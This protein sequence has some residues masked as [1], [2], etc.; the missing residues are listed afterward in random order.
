MRRG[1]HPEE[2][3]DR[4]EDQ[5]ALART[6][7]QTS[8]QLLAFTKERVRRNPIKIGFWIIGLLLCLLFNGEPV[9]DAQL[10]NYTAAID[11]IPHMELDQATD[12]LH[13]SDMLYRQS[14]GWFWTCNTEQCQANKNT[15]EHDLKEVNALAQVAREHQREANAAVGLFSEEGVRNTR[16]L[17]WGAYRKGKQYASN[18]TKMDVLFAGISA[19]GRDEKIGK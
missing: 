8:N 16:G 4:A 13:D 6:L 2:A 14:Q 5:R 7:D 17:F 19:I 1:V 11:K 12:I 15:Y 3:R 10:E 18:R 9:T